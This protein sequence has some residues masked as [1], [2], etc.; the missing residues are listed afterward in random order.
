MLFGMK[1]AATCLFGYGMFVC[2]TEGRGGDGRT[3]ESGQGQG[4][5]LPAASAQA[6]VDTRPLVD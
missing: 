5:S 4:V 2:R 1:L 6:V 3:S